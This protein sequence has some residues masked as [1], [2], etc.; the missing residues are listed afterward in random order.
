MYLF[1]SVTILYAQEKISISGKVTDATSGE[2]LP[3]VTVVVKGTTTGIITDA[4]GNYTIE[5]A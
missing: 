2:V 4:D 5:T 3:G 1:L